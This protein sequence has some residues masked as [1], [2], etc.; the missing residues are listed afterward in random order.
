M[1]VSI[2][3]PTYFINEDSQKYLDLCLESVENLNYPKYL[4]DI[5]VVSSGV[6][7]HVRP[8]YRHY[9]SDERMHF[10]K[11]ANYGIKQAKPDSDLYFI[12][13]D[14]TCCTTDSL[15]NMVELLGNNRMIL[16]P[17]SNCDNTVRYGLILG[18]TKDGVFKEVRNR[19]YRLSDFKGDHEA[20]MKCGSIYPYGL[21]AQEWIAFYATLIPKSVWFEVGGL[22]ENY[23]TGQDDLDFSNRC[24]KLNIPRGVVLNALIW[25]FGGV[26]ATTALDTETRLKNINYYKNK[27]GR[28][29]DS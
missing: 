3:I 13:N 17:I 8:I 2:V 21:I 15:K 24:K 29:P 1:K 9:H 25:H 27:W 20:L 4:L 7:P 11:A 10:P 6:K 26:T 14:D 12:L 16:N 18:Y 22:D 23:L 5:I 19:F 28:L